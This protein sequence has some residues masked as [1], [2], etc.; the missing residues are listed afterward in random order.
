M[1]LDDN[2]LKKINTY[3]EEA[4]KIALMIRELIYETAKN[5]GMKIIEENLKWGEPSFKTPDGTPIRMDWK[6]KTPD[7]FYIFFNCQT[8]MIE[9]CRALYAPKLYFEGK[10]AIVL[11]LSE[12]LPVPILKHCFALALNYHNL[13]KLPLLGA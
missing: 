3:P 5:E 7:S 6:E 2:V 12:E 13:K 10:R 8:L 1:K 9:T 4:K 11:N